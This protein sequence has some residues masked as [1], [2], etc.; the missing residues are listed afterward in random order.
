[1]P[2]LEQSTV[3]DMI[4]VDSDL[5]EINGIKLVK[6]IKKHIDEHHGYTSKVSATEDYK[7]PFIFMYTDDTELLTG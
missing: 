5:K 4:I 2:P 3:I 7:R 6:S 1:M